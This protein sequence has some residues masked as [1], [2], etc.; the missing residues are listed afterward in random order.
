MSPRLSIRHWR[1]RA[2]RLTLELLSTEA[3]HEPLPVVK[4]GTAWLRVLVLPTY[5]RVPELRATPVPDVCELYVPNGDL[6]CCAP[7]ERVERYIERH[8]LKL[9]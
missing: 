9:A 4:I 2:A 1:R 5:G 8:E 7:A 6:D 3:R